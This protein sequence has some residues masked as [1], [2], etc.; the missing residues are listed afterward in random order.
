MRRVRLMPVLLVLLSALAGACSR[1]AAQ[2]EVSPKKLK[3]YGLDH[4]QRLTARLL[5]KKGRPLEI[6]SANWESANKAVAAVDA[7]G[8]VSPKAEGTTTVTAKYDQVRTQ[9]SVEVVDVHVVE[10]SPPSLRIVGPVGTT[11]PVSASVRN[12][13]DR[14]VAITPVWN[15]SHPQVATISADGVVTSVARG[16]T[17][18]V[19][20]VGDV[21]GAAE[22]SVEVRDIARLEIRPA[23]ALVRVGDSQR[24]DVIAYDADGR[25]IEGPAALFKSSDP[26]VAIVSVSGQASGM[27]AGAATIRAAIAGL[28][29]EAT[30]IVN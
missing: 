6:G 30:L 14:S 12:S 5:D 8:L 22:V 11:I 16:V 13:K 26:S 3:I 2:I 1:R 4:P 25:S 24:F 18:L 21:Q 27:K 20:K 17:M 7:G 23:T 9:I 29:A 19:A 28:S 10:V 15:S